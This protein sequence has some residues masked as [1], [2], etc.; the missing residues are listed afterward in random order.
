MIARPVSNDVRNSTSVAGQTMRLAIAPGSFKL[1]ITK[2]TVKDSSVGCI[3]N[4]E[5]AVATVPVR[6]IFPQPKEI[7]PLSDATMVESSVGSRLNRVRKGL[8]RAS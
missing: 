7:D 8:A 5:Q 3:E 1:A 6:T 2:N 4:P